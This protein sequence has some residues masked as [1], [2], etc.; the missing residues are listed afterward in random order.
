MATTS[1]IGIARLAL[2]DALDTGALAGKSFYAWPGPI[3]EKGA[4]E[5]VWISDTP[6][7]ERTIPNIKAGR[8]QRQERYV[9]V[10]SLWVAKPEVGS[11]GA[12]ET[13]ERAVELFAIAENALA[14]DVRLGET[15][16]S[17]HWIQGENSETFLIPYERGWACLIETRIEGQARLT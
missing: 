13:F 4:F 8:K 12:Q 3:V 15:D 17:I 16:P 2:R 1:T 7:W 10:L 14:D 9:F 5:G 11:D 6:E